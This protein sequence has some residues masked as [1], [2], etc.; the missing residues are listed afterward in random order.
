MVQ[1][2]IVIMHESYTT[3]LII[4]PLVFTLKASF[5]KS[6]SASYSTAQPKIILHDNNL[7]FDVRSWCNSCFI[8]PYLHGQ[9]GTQVLNNYFNYCKVIMQLQQQFN[10]YSTPMNSINGKFGIITV[11]CCYVTFIPPLN[12]LSSKIRFY[13]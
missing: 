8:L 1:V 6:S 9:F 12:A 5:L 4:V 7:Y 13:Q 3:Q 10:H 11:V 2:F